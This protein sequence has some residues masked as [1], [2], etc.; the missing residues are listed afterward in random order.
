MQNKNFVATTDYGAEKQTALEV[1]GQPAIGS[2]A[3]AEQPP[4]GSC[5]GGRGPY[6]CW[7]VTPGVSIRTLLVIALDS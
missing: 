3:E 5:M 6:L 4:G 1:V 2:G 7:V